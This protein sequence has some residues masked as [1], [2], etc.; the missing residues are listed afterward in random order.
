MYEWMKGNAYTM[1]ATLATG[2]I[3]L[4][5]SAMTHFQDIRWVMIGLDRDQETVAIKPIPKRD[6][7]LGLVNMEQLQKISMGKGYARISNKGIMYEIQ[8]MMQD[9][10]DGV[11]CRCTFDE[12]EGLLIVH[13]K[14]RL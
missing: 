2:N 13:T 11:K 4:N 6:I 3:T 12:T 10:I 1:I 8:Q 5:S 9:T 14:E 7:D